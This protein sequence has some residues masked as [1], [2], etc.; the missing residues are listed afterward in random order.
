[1]T[2]AGYAWIT[3]EQGI[4][5][6]ALTFAPEGLIGMRLNGGENSSAHIHDALKVIAR[7]FHSFLQTEEGAE[8]T[9]GPPTHCREDGPWTNGAT[10]YR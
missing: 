5:G 1:M 2:R 3:T 4:M 6:E 7:G 10:F 9:S 8:D